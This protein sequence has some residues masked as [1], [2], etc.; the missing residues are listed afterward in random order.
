MWLWRV[1]GIALLAGIGFL[2]WPTPATQL[3]SQEINAG[4]RFQQKLKK[5][6]AT[7]GGNDIFRFDGHPEP[8]VVHLAV[9]D[10]WSSFSPG[11][12]KTLTRRLGEVWQTSRR[13]SGISTGPAVL[14]IFDSSHHEV[15][16]WSNTSGALVAR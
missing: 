4:A 3:S 10:E 13:E 1:L 2:V 14:K 16:E 7:V 9:S 15:S 8:S 6:M 12:K 11:G 5:A